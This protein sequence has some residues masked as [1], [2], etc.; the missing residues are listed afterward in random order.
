MPVYQSKKSKGKW[1]VIIWARGKPHEWTVEGL[2][3]D[4][5]RWEARKRVEL[6][7]DPLALRRAVSFREFSTAVY[8]PF[9][10][11]HLASS[12][13]DNVRIYQVAALVKFFGTSRLTEITATEVEQFKERRATDGLENVSINNELRVLKT[14]LR[15]ALAMGYE[16]TIPQWRRLPERGNGRVKAWTSD[17]LQ[18]L[19][20]ACRDV[21]PE[22][23]PM[24]VYLANT[25]CRKGEAIAAEWSWI[26]FDAGLIR[27]PVNEYWRPKSGRAREVPLAN[28]VRVWLQGTRRHERWVFP[29]FRGCE[30]YVRF[31]EEQFRDVKRA[32]KLSGSPHVLRHSFASHFLARCPDLFL[33]SKILGH[34]STRITELYSHL[35]PGH[36]DRA[37]GVVEISPAMKT[38]DWTMGGGQRETRKSV[39]S[40]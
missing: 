21:C 13:W 2:K 39:K 16:V 29:T 7:A 28:A 15:H 33:L 35:L 34:S 38:V 4:A 18:R 37:K 5:E 30:R 3:R 11:K 25:G 32:A 20:D 24:V 12:T 36:L 22:I 6:A 9:A 27:I 1:R 10:E 31:P 14:V 8:E 19:F 17:E 23:L 40:G 26:D